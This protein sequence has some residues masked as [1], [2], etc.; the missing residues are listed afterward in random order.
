MPRKRIRVSF[1]LDARDCS[2]ACL[3]MVARYFGMRLS[4]EEIRQASGQDNQGVSLSGLVKAASSF[5]FAATS[6]KSTYDEARARLQPPFIVFWHQGHYVVLEKFTKYGVIL[7]DPAAGRLRYSRSEF[8]ELWLTNEGRVPRGILVSLRPQK[9]F[10]PTTRGHGA[11][12]RT[13]FLHASLRLM[14]K[15]LPGVLLSVAMLMGIQFVAPFINSLIIDDGIQRGVA[16][17][18]LGFSVLQLFFV[19]VQAGLQ[20]L[21]AW[22]MLHV[23]VHINVALADSFI[24]KLLKVRASFFDGRQTGD[25]IQRFGDQGMIQQA[26]SVHLVE[27]IQGLVTVAVFAGVLYVIDGRLFVT[28]AV[29]VSLFVAMTV[30]L[31]GKQRIQNYKVFRASSQKQSAML[32]LFDTMPDIRLSNAEDDRRKIFLDTYDLL[33]RASLK[34]D[35]LTTLQRCSSFLL[36][37]GAAVLMLFLVSRKALN[38]NITIGIVV[39]TQ[40]VLGQLAQPIMHLSVLASQ[41]QAAKLSFDRSQELHSIVNEDIGHVRPTELEALSLKGVCFSYPGGPIVLND[42]SFDLRKGKTT[43]IVGKSGSGKSTLLRLLLK[44]DTPT[45][46]EI[47][48][49]GCLLTDISTRWWREECAVVT[50]EGKLLADSLGVN[51]SLGRIVDP[52]RLRMAAEMAQIL[53]FVDSLPRKFDTRVGRDGIGLSR[54]QLQRVLLARAFY[55]ESSMLLLDEATSALDTENERCI[56]EAIKK[57]GKNKTC[58]IIAHRLSTV[59]EADHIIVLDRGRVVEEGPHRE[60]LE[61][62]GFY[63]KL[64]SHQLYTERYDVTT[65]S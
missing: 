55:K 5:G 48:V 54:G 2:A 56:V 6:I 57:A 17:V 44:L 45:A 42:I 23:G 38:L 34:S 32:D 8:E 7:A 64:V 33:A 50:Q 35:S 3:D 22:L 37:E 58:L 9:G 40:Y 24:T 60:L 21:Q 25:L 65:I 26:V 10:I 53:D 43:A 49:G 62:K 63:M 28:Y 16:E 20:G 52:A 29:V 59:R 11:G 19:A 39:A 13:A 36:F 31:L 51:I 1:Q 47:K 18:V 15:V 41:W 30:L 12:E 46:G 14:V 4:R 61:R 27:C